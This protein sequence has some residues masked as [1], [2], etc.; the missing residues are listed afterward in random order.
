MPPSVFADLWA[1]VKQGKSWKGL[2]KNRS[3][4]GNFYWVY[5]HVTPVFEQSQIIGYVSVRSKPTRA[6]VSESADLY[7]RINQGTTSFQPTLK[8]QRFRLRSLLSQKKSLLGLISLGVVCQAA[9]LY[10]GGN[11]STAFSFAAIVFS[12]MAYLSFV[13]HEKA[14]STK[15]EDR[16]HEL[17]DKLS[18]V[19]AEMTKSSKNF[20]ET[21]RCL[22]QRSAE[23]HGIN[24]AQISGVVQT[25]AAV[26]LLTNQVENSVSASTKAATFS[27][28][29][30]ENAIEGGK[31]M[32]E[33]MEAMDV[34]SKG[35]EEVTDIV[36]VIDEIAFQTNLLALN[37]SVEAAH[38]GDTGR[39]FAIVANEVRTLSQRTS[40]AAL[41]IK[42][43]I[44][45]S[46]D[47]VAAGRVLVKKSNQKLEQIVNVASTV[48]ELVADISEQSDQQRV[49]IDEVNTAMG[50]MESM[51]A[52]NSDLAEQTAQVSTFLSTQ[53]EGL[54]ELL[55]F[56]VV[57]ETELR[58]AG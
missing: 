43:L 38:A 37:A 50:D 31:V 1:T 3:K 5:A 51:T 35:S 8:T 52:K 10:L 27:A 34:I 42:N 41:E 18:Y 45:N 13:M 16:V 4:N 56:F 28:Q 12:L 7:N 20:G 44:S 15:G 36:R 11:A 48:S 23:L 9:A 17:I 26:K 19:L 53:S 21:S 39:G 47:Q 46:S 40:K 55:G 58:K 33:T 30:R 54:D 49:S 24:E 6:E 25:Q 2:V 22:E 57:D 32:Q 14:T 29:A